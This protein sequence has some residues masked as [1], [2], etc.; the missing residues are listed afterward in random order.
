MIDVDAFP[1]DTSWLFE[2]T[3]GVH[4]FGGGSPD[5]VGAS[6]YVSHDHDTLVL[7]DRLWQITATEGISALWLSIVIGSPRY[8]TLLCSIATGTSNSMKNISREAFLT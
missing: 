3:T 5:L 7:P 1:S 6:S 4:Q 8:R 2:P